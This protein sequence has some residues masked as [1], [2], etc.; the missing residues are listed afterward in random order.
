MVK[1]LESSRVDFSS[2]RATAQGLQEERE[3]P[4]HLQLVA[5]GSRELATPIPR[6]P[7][8]EN[9]TLKVHLGW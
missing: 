4:A 2:P 1:D 5:A 9:A 7:E 8:E 6:G 3:F